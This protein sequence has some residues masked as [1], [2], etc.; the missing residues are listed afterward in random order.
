MRPW[1]Q[2]RPRPSPLPHH[3]LLLCIHTSASMCLPDGV[4]AAACGCW[5]RLAVVDSDCPTLTRHSYACTEGCIALAVTLLDTFDAEIKAPLLFDELGGGGGSSDFAGMNSSVTG[6]AGAG[7]PAV[8]GKG[9]PSLDPVGTGTDLSFE[10]EGEGTGGLS[11]V[12]VTSLLEGSCDQVGGLL[13]HLDW[14]FYWPRLHRQLDAMLASIAGRGLHVARHAQSCV[15]SWSFPPIWRVLL[16]SFAALGG[17]SWQ[18]DAIASLGDAT[19]FPQL[20][21]AVQSETSCSVLS[22]RLRSVA[23]CLSCNCCCPPSSWAPSATWA[24]HFAS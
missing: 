4:L 8:G 22:C 18:R 3:S 6:V 17:H 7:A 23:R 15:W 24:S 20:T 13:M 21:T 16:P 19:S 12:S 10:A 5:K 2:A 1:L 11:S 9:K 14:D